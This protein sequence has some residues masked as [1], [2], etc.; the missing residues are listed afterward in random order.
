MNIRRIASILMLLGCA[1]IS[2]C[3]TT[4]PA[5]PLPPPPP[6]Q[7]P[8]GGC[9][10][11]Q[12]EGTFVITQVFEHENGDGIVAK[13]T[14]QPDSRPQP[15]TALLRYTRPPNLREG[16]KFRGSSSS[17]GGSCPPSTSYI[18]HVDGVDYHLQD[19]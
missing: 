14:F 7:P 9:S 8:V 12:A 15:E 2:A 6:P 18:M 4:S 3:T 16:L 19:R 13:A 11:W 10:N 17:F 5:A 1:A